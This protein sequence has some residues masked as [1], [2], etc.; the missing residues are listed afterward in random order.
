MFIDTSNA[1]S[2]KQFL[3]QCSKEPGVYKMISSTGE[4]IYVGKA[5]NLAKRL[6][7]YFNKNQ[8]STKVAK[9]V[10]QLT[11]IETTV[12][13]TE[14]E[15]LIL[16]CNLIKELKPKY[17]ILLRDDKSYPYICLSHHDFPR[18][19][20][21]RGK[22]NNDA[23]CFGPYPNV[24][25]AKQAIRFIQQVFLLRVCS[26][27]YFNNRSRPCLLYQINRCSAPC[28]NYT[29]NQDYFERVHNAKLFLKGNNQQLIKKI[30]DKMHAAS[31]QQDYEQAAVLRDQIKKIQEVIQG[32]F[33]E[34][35]AKESMKPTDVIAI[36]FEANL[37][38]VAILKF[39]SGKLV[40]SNQYIIKNNST[41]E[42]QDDQDLLLSVLSQYY[43]NYSSDN[44]QDIIINFD[45]DKNAMHLLSEVLNNSG[46]KISIH[47]KGIK[48]K[49]MN[50]A[51][52]NS[53]ELLIRKSELQSKYRNKFN[54]LINALNSQIKLGF[55]ECF[56]ISHT[57][58]KQT[59]AS[60][61]VFDT[62]GPCKDKYRRYNINSTHGDDVSAMKQ[63]LLRRFKKKLEL[64]LANEIP[65]LV[66]IDG[67]KAQVNA[68]KTIFTELGLQKIMILGIT[69]GEGRRAI[70]DRII[71]AH[72]L[73]EVPFVKHQ[74]ALMLLQEMRDEA[75]RFAIVGHRKKRDKE[76]LSSI[77]DEIPGIGNT[78]RKNLL[79]YLG[80]WQQVYNAKPEE[81]SN[82]PGISSKM[83]ELIYNYLHN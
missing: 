8:V 59:I 14:V 77:L 49:W 46:L 16:E 65:D 73:G 79:S 81:L 30:S 53:N 4:I 50:L 29:H 22:K 24:N 42:Q 10:S 57:F 27:N 58:G 15:A 20:L 25:A 7:S 18:L 12:T 52:K 78:R 32:Q 6:A 2:I 56:D 37:I 40:T 35:K 55:I 5:K 75:H 63:V 44:P 28:V 45:F 17:N 43:L 48:Q 74:S 82:V 39:R 76:Q 83:A 9:L 33:V 80:G 36:Q 60:C 61:V 34:S 19:L 1:D 70:N 38:A 69:K 64:N 54:D 71:S 11:N 41:F 72:S 62:N 26:D 47:P 68:A 67:G 23:D 66:L 3:K 31:L 21:Y 13:N 51:I